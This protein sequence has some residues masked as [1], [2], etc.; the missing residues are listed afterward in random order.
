MTAGGDT[1]LVAVQDWQ[2]LRLEQW[3]MPACEFHIINFK[4]SPKL[5]GDFA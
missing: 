1:A 3:L 2:N 5:L 4:A